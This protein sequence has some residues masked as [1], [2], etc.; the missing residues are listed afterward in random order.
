M[1][2]SPAVPDPGDSPKRAVPV[3]EAVAPVDGQGAPTNPR[4]EDPLDTGDYL[5][6]FNREEVAW[7][8]NPE[9]K[10]SNS[11]HWCPKGS[12]STEADT[13]SE[14]AISDDEFVASEA[15]V[16]PS[17][18]LNSSTPT[19]PSSQNSGNVSELKLLK[20]IILDELGTDLYV[21]N[22]EW[23]QSLYTRIANIPSIERFLA[24]PEN[25]YVDGS[26]QAI[27]EA[28]SVEREIYPPLV[29][30]L[31]SIVSQFNTSRFPGVSRE[32]LDTNY[33]KLK[34]D[35]CKKSTCPD[36][37]IKASGPSF[38]L[39][40]EG[41]ANPSQLEVQAG[42]SNITSV[43]EVKLGKYKNQI[44]EHAKQLSMYCRQILLQQPNRN[45]VRFLLITEKEVRLVHFDRSGV[46]FSPFIN[47]HEDPHTFIRLVVGIS[48]CNEKI[49][50]LDTSVKWKIDK[51]TGKKIS[52]TVKHFDDDGITTVYN[53]VMDSRPFIRASIRGRGTICY[54]AINSKTG[55]AVVI[56][57]S[58]RT[59]GREPESSYL[60]AAKGLK[61]VAQAVSYSNN[62]GETKEYRPKGANHQHYYNRIKSRVVI[63]EYGGPLE[64]F[65]T[66]FQLISAIRDAIDGHRK[67][68]LLK[69]VLHRDVSPR[70]ILL[71]STDDIGERGILIDLDMAVWINRAMSDISKDPRTGAQ[72]W[73]SIALLR[74]RALEKSDP[75]RP[76]PPHN[77]LD[78][79]ESFYYILCYFLLVYAR[80]GA[81]PS[82]AALK[83]FA[84]TNQH[85]VDQAEDGKV[86]LLTQPISS[87]C[88][89]WWGDV[90]GDLVED[91]RTILNLVHAAQTRIQTM[92]EDRI[93]DEGRIQ[94]YMEIADNSWHCY[95]DIIAAFDKALAI[96]QSEDVDEAL[97][98]SDAGTPCP[99]ERPTQSRAQTLNQPAKSVTQAH[100][101][102]LKRR[103]DVH[104]HEDLPQT[105]RKQKSVRVVDPH[106]RAEGSAE[107]DGD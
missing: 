64:I 91:Y 23:A 13:E 9:S 6:R 2:A 96:I 45:F 102:S 57:D 38:E 69:K 7:A 76:S 31:S 51:S 99:P 26:W 48:T 20:S 11:P 34:H 85:D 35:D 107:S 89:R 50:G 30:I 70:N 97:A 14:S 68:L 8:S 28:P 87:G 33:V 37:S 58:W 36:I 75:P 83:R 101:S 5:V 19:R 32:V 42:W 63:E 86:G 103:L 10:L 56:K 71:G 18:Y 21:V 79:L 44:T 24:N 81:L 4:D 105:K 90:C 54:R 95:D 22:I 43:V 55:K 15:D 73:Q 47:F 29:K 16:P 40:E 93:T 65:S 1:P 59:E 92:N 62:C 12:Q 46:Y 84:K 77:Y 17:S 74:S 66:R 3:V 49:L 98:D 104:Q 61:G 94:K 27:P 106:P 25:G 82:Q 88:S 78:D 39:P 67:L 41:S 53:I 60:M 72:M 52:G 100:R 80:P